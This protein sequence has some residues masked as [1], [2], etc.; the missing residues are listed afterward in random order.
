MFALVAITSAL[1]LQQ[2]APVWTLTEELR[3]GGVDGPDALTAVGAVI[4]NSDERL[5]YVSQPGEPTI[6]SFDAESGAFMAAFGRAGEGPGEFRSITA[7]AFRSDTLFASDVFQQRYSAFSPRGELYLTRKI[8][9]APVPE[10]GRSVSPVVPATG[11]LFWGESVVLV[12][13][14]AS[15]RW[16]EQP[17]VLMDESGRILATVATK[18]LEEAATSVAAG[19]RVFLFMQP[20]INLH[21]LHDYAPDGSAMV[22]VET[23]EPRSERGSFIVTR[24]T[25]DRDTVFHRSYSYD[26]RPIPSEVR[27][28]IYHSYAASFGIEPFARAMRVAREHVVVPEVAPPIEAVL[29]D[30]RGRTWLMR[31]MAPENHANL[32]ILS[33]SG[34]IAAMASLPKGVTPMHVSDTYLWGVE[35][36]PLGVPYLIRYRIVHP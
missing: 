34:R 14:V 15:G 12:G 32:I 26:A 23:S 16:T 20:L 25:S 6:R 11:D 27:D 4:T 36:D 31:N 9:S 24:Q 3:I 2:P 8:V 5:V 22:V 17:V 28:S 10:T 21:T 7:L 29:A 13:A 19:N 33:P 1:L 35:H 30:T 18:R